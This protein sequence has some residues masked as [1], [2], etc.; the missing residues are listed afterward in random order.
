MKELDGVDIPALSVTKDG[1]C[2]NDTVAAADAENRGWWTC[3]GYIR[4]T[5]IDVCPDKLDWGLKYV[6]DEVAYIKS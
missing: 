6:H 5:D 2:E 3:G 4:S 1:T